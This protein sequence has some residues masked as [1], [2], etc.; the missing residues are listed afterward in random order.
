MAM[1]HFNTFK[2]KEFSFQIYLLK[3]F[4]APWMFL[5]WWQWLLQTQEKL[6]FNIVS[7]FW[8]NYGQLMNYFWEIAN[9][10]QQY[11]WFFQRIN[12][13]CLNSKKAKQRIWRNFFQHNWSFHIKHM[14][15]KLLG[16]SLTP[17]IKHNSWKNLNK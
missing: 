17:I 9:I 13:I 8:E 1:G 10:L 5:V 12:I 4:R 6:E 11:I 16:S 14:I 7:E 2:I 3:V 15:Q